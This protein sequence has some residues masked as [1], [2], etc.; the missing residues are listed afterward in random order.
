MNFCSNKEIKA[1]A[2]ELFLGR[3]I[4]PV[5]VTILYICISFTLNVCVAIPQFGNGIVFFIFSEILTLAINTFFGLLDYG[6]NTFYLNFSSNREFSL[7]DMFSAFKSNPDRILAVSFI[8]SLLSSILFLPYTIYT[9]FFIE[10]NNVNV[11]TYVNVA[12]L[13]IIGRI[14]FYIIN[15]WFAPV[16]FVLADIPD[17]NPI[18][19]I[20][21][22]FWLMK[23]RIFKYILLQIS[24]IPLILLGLISFGIGMLWITPYTKICYSLFYLDTVKTKTGK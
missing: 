7:L 10:V 19:A 11:Y 6:M 14:V 8:L 5:T 22:S 20:K 15:L 16:Y 18:K 4:M 23:G 21:L 12:V 9:S 17:I 2:K 3:M 1:D 24:F 13:L